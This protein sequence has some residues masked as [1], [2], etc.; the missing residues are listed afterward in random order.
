MLNAFCRVAPSVRLSFLAI[1]LARLRCLA[2]A[3]IV[4]TS[5]GVQ[6]RTFLVFM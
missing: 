5:S 6:A 3:L 2:I 4:R 1:A